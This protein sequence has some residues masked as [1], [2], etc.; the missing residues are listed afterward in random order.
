MAKKLIT[1]K[2]DQAEI[3]RWKAA[4]EKDGR[5]LSAICRAALDRVAVRVEKSEAPQ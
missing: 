1:F 5:S 3:D 4:L 2:A